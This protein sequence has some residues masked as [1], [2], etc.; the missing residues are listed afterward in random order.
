MKLE[1]KFSKY[2]PGGRN[3]VCCGPNP[4]FRKKHNRIVK[5]RVKEYA[6]KETMLILTELQS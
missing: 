4:A 5:K 6:R 2:G 3:C 1:Q